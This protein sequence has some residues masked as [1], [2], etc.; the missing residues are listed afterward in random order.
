MTQQSY[1]ILTLLTVLSVLGNYFSLP[2]FFGVDIIFGSIAVL[3]IIHLFGAGWGMIVALLASCYT[4]FQWGHP[5]GMLVFTLEMLFIGL[6]WQRYSHNLLLLEGIFWLCL[7][8]P[9]I[10]LVYTYTIPLDTAQT[11][12]IA[13]KSFVNGMANASIACLLITFWPLTRWANLPVSNY[14]P[15][16]ARILLNLMAA[17]VLLPALII[18]TFSGWQ[19]VNQIKKDIQADLNHLSQDI[20]NDFRLLSRQHIRALQGLAQV[21]AKTD[22]PDSVYFAQHAGQILV[23]FPEF[24]N[25]TLTDVK[26]RLIFNYPIESNNLNLKSAAF[27]APLQSVLTTPQVL[28][29]PSTVTQEGKVTPVMA[30]A[31]SIQRDG[32][33]AGAMIVYFNILKTL[34]K[35]H[36][37]QQTFTRNAQITFTDKHG[38]IISSTSSD[39]RLLNAYERVPNT[40]KVWRTSAIYPSFSQKTTHIMQRW[41]DAIYVQHAPVSENLP[42]TV[43][44]EKPLR[45]YIES[46]QPFYVNQV[47]MIFIIT[48][49][50]LILAMIISRWLVTPL[51]RLAHFTDNLPERINKVSIIQWPNSQFREIDLLTN[52]FKSIAKLLTARFEEIHVTKKSR[53]QCVPKTHTQEYWHEQVLL[54]HLI[55]S[56]PDLIC[57]KDCEGAYLGCNKA[58]E[59]FVGLRELDLIGKTDLDGL[60]QKQAI[61]CHK[62]DQQLLATGKPYVHETCATYP[63]GQQ[64]LLDSL[65]TPFFAPD[66]RVLGFISISRDITARKQV[67]EALRQSQDMLRL[68]IDNIPQFIFW[69]DKKG[70]Y[71]GCNQ[72]FAKIVGFESPETIVGKTDDDLKPFVDNAQFLE[73]LNHCISVNGAYLSQHLEFLP[74]ANGTC[75]WLEINQIPLHNAQ[76]QDIGVL[77]SFEDITERKQAEEKL[78]QWVNVLEKSTE[79]IL[80]TDAQTRIL[81]VNKAFTQMTGYSE[82]DVL[83][84]HPN[85]LSSGKHASDFYKKMWFSINTLGNWEGEIW[86]R[87]KNGEI[88]PEWQHIS[89]IK[90]DTNEQVTNY[91]AIFSD[92]TL[93]K[94]TEQR[95]TYLAHY[96]DL[97]GLPNRHLFYERVT[98]ALYLAQ[99]QRGIVAVMFLDLDDFKYV[100]DTWGHLVGDLLLKQVANRLT[101]CLCKTDTIAHFGGDDFTIVLENI[102]HT[103][104]V[105]Q[106]AQNLLHKMQAPFD[107]NGHE[108]FVTASIG[109]SVYPSDSQD[110]ETLLKN[111]DAAMYSAK[112][113]GKNNYQFVTAQMNRIF[114]NRLVM[115]TQLHH[116]LERDEF[117][118]YYQPQMHLG[119]GNIVGAEVLLRWQHPEKGLMLPY[120]FIPLAEETGLIVAL[121][122]WVLRHTCLQQQYWRN[123]N[124]FTLRLSVNLS[125]RQF[126]QDNLVASVMRI[127]EETDVDATL[128]EL[129]LTESTL[130]QDVDVATHILHQFKE[131]GIQLAIDDFGTGYSSLSYLKRFPVDTLKIDQSFVRDVPTDKDDVSITKAIIALAHSLRIKVIAEG[132]ETESQLAFL[133]SLAC[134]EVQG[135]LIGYPLPKHEFI[136]L[137]KGIAPIVQSPK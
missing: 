81:Q 127:L 21:V 36:T 18:I 87:R 93:R 83:S 69:K 88:Y 118:L 95:L 2:L 30:Y 41:Y 65:K 101:E 3:L 1:L 96:N 52:N 48:L 92:L 43:V 79:A 76:G 14:R 17:L 111:A 90:D 26:G 125:F 54:R 121:G 60:S 91:L 62:I 42:M 38:I 114:H 77:G 55:D 9:V 58:F 98:R 35:S 105:E 85:I 8:M 29:F 103:K 122:E 31:M 133:K 70:G 134:D 11:S 44:V 115:E 99:Q 97:T 13:F 74:L 33:I 51:L 100:N 94:Q 19:T 6:T 59:K 37:T 45:G 53:E 75:L 72:N 108:T 82:A 27:H 56:I 28:T 50:G 24:L 67:E 102:Y 106:F 107:L 34:Y 89:V 61:C 104:E 57:Y 66:G 132:V 32:Q 109:I 124:D 120:T 129:E 7:G 136:K 135:Y 10:W 5:Y 46:W 86:N 47:T 23:L 16:L 4:F 137:V 78:R 116:A 20:T 68:V 25:L 123:H 22:L 130:M 49:A 110:V 131:M 15:S 39:L 119:S 73:M 113:R 128:L 80:I 63:D 84:K 112:K 71:L 12:L 64:V 117:V 40:L 126:K